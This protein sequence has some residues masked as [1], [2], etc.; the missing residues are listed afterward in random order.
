M[1]C[2]KD[3]KNFFDYYK[4]SYESKRYSYIKS[5]RA[6]I[7]KKPCKRKACIRC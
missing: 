3:I 2:T 7:I 6:D 1:V 4:E 5:I